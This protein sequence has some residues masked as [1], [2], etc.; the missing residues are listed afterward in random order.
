MTSEPDSPPYH[1]ALRVSRRHVPLATRQRARSNTVSD[2]CMQLS[3]KM[4]LCGFCG[5]EGHLLCTRCK[6]MSYCSVMCQNEDW[7][8][9]RH[10]CKSFEA[11]ER[12]IHAFA[13]SPESKLVNSTII[14]RN[15]LKDLTMTKVV[16]GEEFQAIVMEFYSPAQF[17]LLKKIPE[18]TEAMQII[19]AEL[20]KSPSCVN[21]Y[22]PNLGEICIVQFSS[23][24]Q[25]YR[26]QVLSLDE[27]QKMVEILYIDFGNK[28]NV[29]VNRI[30]ALCPNMAK[31]SPC[32]TE[33]Y[34][35]GVVPMSCNWSDICSTAVR[36]LLQGHEV[37]A[38]V[39]ETSVHG[40][41]VDVM[42][43]S[44]QLLS[45]FLLEH[46][47]AKEPIKDQTEGDIQTLRASS[48]DCIR[49]CSNGQDDDGGTPLPCSVTPEVGT[50]L[51][52]VVTHIHSP[53]DIIV[54]NI[55]NAGLIQDLQLQLRDHCSLASNTPNFRPSP[56]TVCCAQ[57]S[58]DKLWYRAK[59]LYYS[60]EEHLCV[61]YID[62]GNIEEVHQACLRPI[63]PDLLSLPVQ[64]LSFSLAGV[65]PVG[66]RW[67]EASL[68]AFQQR[69]S[70]RILNAKILDVHN[71]KPLVTLTDH[72]SDPEANIAE[73]LISAG[74]ASLG[75]VAPNADQET[76]A[77]KV[78]EPLKWS[79][80]ELPPKG[81][82]AVLLSTV[83][84]HPQ[85]FYC[86]VNS[87]AEE[88]RRSQ[89]KAELTRH[90]EQDTLPFMPKVGEP[91]CAMSPS[92][93]SWSRAIV[94]ELT[95]DKLKVEFMDYGY[96]LMTE[97]DHIRSIT[98]QLLTLPFHA[99]HCFLT[100]VEPLGSE[101]SS[102]AILWFQNMLDGEQLL[103]R[104]TTV[105]AD[106]YGVELECRGENVASALISK[107]LAKAP[108]HFE[109]AA[110]N[111]VLQRGSSN[112]SEPRTHLIEPS[113]GLSFSMDWKSIEL[114][115]ND[116]FHPHVAAVI[117]PNL[118][119]LLGHN[120][121]VQTALEEVMVELAQYC[122]DY[123]KRG[124]APDYSALVSGAACCAQ[125]SADNQWYRAVVLDVGVNEVKVIYADYGNMETIPLSMILPIPQHLLHLPFQIVRC[126]LAVDNLYGAEWT[127]YVT[128]LFESVMLSNVL[129]TVRSF[130]GTSNVLS[131]SLPAEI[132]SG[133]VIDFLLDSLLNHTREM[134]SPTVEQRD[135]KSMSDEDQCQ[136]QNAHQYPTQTR[137]KI[138]AIQPGAHDGC[139]CESLK[140]KIEHLE[141]MMVQKLSLLMELI[142]RKSGS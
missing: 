76:V 51:S 3:G 81:Q 68:L 46:S 40:H 1:N 114:P 99:V 50:S 5:H 84:N 2:G 69:L 48:I 55:E 127:E 137:K 142:E 77:D 96:T 73:M 17:F 71:G 125:F 121:V 123:R 45:S 140:A 100:G 70:N 133:D 122:C 111:F 107:Q 87:P 118:F 98:P 75:P 4:N 49:H 30:R 56:G 124:P 38:W 103:T 136:V 129:A 43:S 7:K 11:E 20:Q 23:D 116:V 97:K 60:S 88:Q 44:G 39:I 109:E 83:V 128:E 19:S 47:F 101:W 105:N 25:W 82:T 102:E 110:G 117:S 29:P 28:E 61:F 24:M 21:P 27:E 113:S 65:Q 6:K 10:I 86:Y 135:K 9:H 106:G 62:F 90:C 35:A 94:K 74:Y 131:L 18:V 16:K 80:F 139:C 66:G 79:S 53:D 58:E 26:G 33:C 141:Q 12:G 22:M 31:F 119:Y 93:G 132:G 63:G 134:H 130:D 72:A 64:A 42:T 8:A 41:G 32:A 126:S 15:L 36:Q 52:V 34:V 54:Q 138:T 95:E 112:E 104:V 115:L 85:D 57:F 120:K 13:S 14:S 91:C 37:T 92:D 89:L 59:I 67:S 78:A 108:T